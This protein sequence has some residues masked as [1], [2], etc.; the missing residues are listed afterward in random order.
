MQKL[1]VFCKACPPGTTSP[2]GST[3]SAACSCGNGKEPGTGRCLTSAP[4]RKPTAKPTTRPTFRCGADKYEGGSDALCGDLGWQKFATVTDRTR[5]YDGGQYQFCYKRNAPGTSTKSAATNTCEAQGARLCTRQELARIRGELPGGNA[6]WSSTPC[7][8]GG[9][10]STSAYT[11]VGKNEP[12]TCKVATTQAGTFCCADTGKVN[13][14]RCFDCPSN[15][16][17]SKANSKTVEDCQCDSGFSGPDGGT[18][19]APT[20]APT[21]RPTTAQKSCVANEYLYGSSQTCADLGLSLGSGSNTCAKDEFNGAC[22]AAM[23]FANAKSYCEAQGMRLCRHKTE[24]RRNRGGLSCTG[25]VE[26]AWLDKPCNSAGSSYFTA[27]RLN[28]GVGPAADDGCKSKSSTAS[29]VCC[30]DKK[31]TGYCATCPAGSTSSAGSKGINSCSC[32]AGTGINSASSIG[33][34]CVNICN[35]YTGATACRADSGCQWFGAS[36]FPDPNDRCCGQL[37]DPSSVCT[38]R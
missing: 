8:S 34:F 20:P 26:R 1:K 19:K 7:C 37:T 25:P 4:T 35:T 38:A 15:S 5:N 27:N 3:S 22:P 14:D 12:N 24:L 30:A 17:H 36:D 6:V 2:A 13:Q 29:V 11:T 28:G 23:T 32:P 18:C 31:T 10:C 21:A 33:R 9:T 16:G